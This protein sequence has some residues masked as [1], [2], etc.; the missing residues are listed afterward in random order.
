MKKQIVAALVLILFISNCSI[1]RSSKEVRND[2]HAPLNENEI[3]EKIPFDKLHKDI[4]YFMEVLVEVHVNPY[5]NIQKDMFCDEVRKLK[6]NIDKPL[7]RK[8][9]Y[10]VS[11]PVI[12]LLKDSHTNTYFPQEIFNHYNKKDGNLF[13]TDITVAEDKKVYVKND[14]SPNA[15]LLPTLYR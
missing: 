4:D 8:E 13:P 7:T 2:I 12:L 5:L 3:T 15:I 10:Q 6:T 14:Y 9:F 1:K 11:T